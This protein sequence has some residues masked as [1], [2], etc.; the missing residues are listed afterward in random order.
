MKKQYFNSTKAAILFLLLVILITQIPFHYTESQFKNIIY[1]K[2]QSQENAE[3]QQFSIEDKKEKGLLEI[4]AFSYFKEGHQNKGSAVFVK[5]LMFPTYRLES[6][7]VKP[8][9]NFSV[10]H[11]VTDIKEINIVEIK[12]TDIQITYTEPV[13]KKNILRYLFWF[14]IYEV[15]AILRIKA[16]KQ[17]NKANQELEG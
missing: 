4:Y 8:Y 1:K 2:I 15:V 11:A 13:L 14:V 7:Y 3:I 10:T 5:N 6:F 17:K 12:G 16:R 9:E